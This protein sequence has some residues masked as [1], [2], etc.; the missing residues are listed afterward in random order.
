MLSYWFLTIESNSFIDC[1]V[2]THPS[3]STLDHF[4]ADFQAPT[5]HTTALLYVHS[6][7]HL[8]CFHSLFQVLLRVCVFFNIGY[9]KSASEVLWKIK[10]VL[11][12]L[13]VPFC[14][15]AGSWTSKAKML[16][17]ISL[18]CDCK[19]EYFSVVL[20]LYISNFLHK[21]WLTFFHYA[22]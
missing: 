21:N 16:A 7:E 17:A 22:M 10:R 2:V 18:S 1:R 11:V 14:R 4:D 15:T 20:C 3:I 6:L 9:Q 13:C 5:S 19:F 8:L 12:A